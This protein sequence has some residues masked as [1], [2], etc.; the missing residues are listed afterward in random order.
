[1][2]KRKKNT[3]ATAAGGGVGGGAAAAAYPLLSM[4]KACWR[5]GGKFL[6]LTVLCSHI[7]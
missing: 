3:P 5:W 2:E 1:M 7:H 4:N 6:F